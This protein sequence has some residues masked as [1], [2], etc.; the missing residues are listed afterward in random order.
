MPGGREPGRAGKQARGTRKHGC[1]LAFPRSSH[2]DPTLMSSSK[3][4]LNFPSADVVPLV[5]AL[6]GCV[7]RTTYFQ[8]F[9][10]AVWFNQIRGGGWKR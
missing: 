2:P 9:C 6:S 3:V 7:V 10:V 4:V 8:S 1:L 5:F